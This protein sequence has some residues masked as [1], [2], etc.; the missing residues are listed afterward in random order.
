[1]PQDRGHLLQVIDEGPG[2]KENMA[3]ELTQAFRR[4]DQRY[5][6]SGLGLNIVTRIVQ[7]HQGRLTLE[8][9]QDTSGLNAQCWLPENVLNK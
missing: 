4:M 1:M 6:G 2:V 9:R 8:N 3:S 7:L 5:G